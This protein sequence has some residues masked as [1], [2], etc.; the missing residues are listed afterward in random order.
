MK[1]IYTVIDWGLGGRAEHTRKNNRE[2]R[3]RS[4]V[5]LLSGLRMDLPGSDSL[6]TPHR[7]RVGE[8][9]LSPDKIV[10]CRRWQMEWEGGAE[11]E[12]SKSR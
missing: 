12:D 7:R 8:F 11:S 2:E 9:L 4:R 3:V 6:V 1:V 10:R 5:A